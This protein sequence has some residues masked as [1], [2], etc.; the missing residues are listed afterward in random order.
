[1]REFNALKD[2]PQPKEPRYVSPDIRTVHSRIIASSRGKEYYDGDRKNG[3][4]GFKYDGR[5][6]K[7]AEFMAWFHRTLEPSVSR[8]GKIDLHAKYSNII[9]NPANGFTPQEQ[10]SFMSVY[11]ILDELTGDRQVLQRDEHPWQSIFGRHFGRYR[12]AP[13]DFEDKGVSSPL[14][15]VA[16]TLVHPDMPLTTE[17][18]MSF[19]ADVAVMYRDLGKSAGEEVRTK[20][21][22]PAHFQR[23]VRDV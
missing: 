16:K 12:Y 2:Y 14:R 19:I 21:R 20:R 13:I 7:I 22:D 3:Y 4:G 23:L 5:W 8:T 18:I 9:E 11:Y 17:T 10:E 1:M 15:D 6:K